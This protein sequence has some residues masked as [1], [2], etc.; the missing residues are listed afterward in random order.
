M[1]MIIG[2]AETHVVELSR[3]LAALGHDVTVASN[4][5]VYV[6]ELLRSGV[7]HFTVPLHTKNPASMMKSYRKLKKL[8]KREKFDIV[9]AHSRIPAFICGALSRRMGFRFVTSTH[10]V[11]KVN[12]LLE[13]VSDWGE[14][15]FAVSSDIK[16]YLIDNY[17]VPSDLITLTINGIDTERFS[18]K[19]SA[20]GVIAELSLKQDDSVS[21]TSAVL[22]TKRHS[23]DFF[24]AMRQRDLSVTFQT[25]KSL[26]S[27]AVR[28][29]TRFLRERQK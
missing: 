26:S 16:Q 12:P 9:H 15:T 21:F 20:D 10:A 1:W 5:G 2:G 24:Y 23:R 8:I 28:L 6:D 22:T 3:G 29:M 4:G 13:K 17:E 18:K 25:L 27:A 14:R 11:F 19:A 7:K